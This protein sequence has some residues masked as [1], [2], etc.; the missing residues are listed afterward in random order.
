MDGTR[1]ATSGLRSWIIEIPW[2][3]THYPT[4]TLYICPP[5]DTSWIKKLNR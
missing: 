2:K 1:Q 4:S 5:M 3:G